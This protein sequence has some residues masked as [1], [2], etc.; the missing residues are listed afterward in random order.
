MKRVTNILAASLFIGGCANTNT[1]KTVDDTFKVV[2]G[3]SQG[4]DTSP[5]SDYASRRDYMGNSYYIKVTETGKVI[6][7]HEGMDF[8]ANS[9][10]EV[11]APTKGVVAVVVNDNPYRGGRVTIQTNIEY[12]HYQAGGGATANLYVDVLHVRPKPNLAVGNKV[13]AGEVIG[14]VQAADRPEIGPR[15]HVHF[16]AGPIPETWIAHTDPNQFWQKGA[17]RVT[18]FDPK[19]PPSGNEIIAPIR[20]R[21]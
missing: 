12:D 11:I 17:G 2:V 9:G 4:S 20:C 10:S 16:S 21:K 7:R 18:C 15:P 5:C 8:C 3:A 19:N 6:T 13:Q 1:D 14:F